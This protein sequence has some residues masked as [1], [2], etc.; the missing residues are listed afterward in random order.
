MESFRATLSVSEAMREKRV[1][2]GSPDTAV[3]NIID[4]DGKRCCNYECMYSTTRAGLMYVHVQGGLN[5]LL[6]SYHIES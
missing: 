2:V 5:V 4:N 1:S 3:V 6:Q